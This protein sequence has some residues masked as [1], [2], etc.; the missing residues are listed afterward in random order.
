MPRKG[1]FR[2]RPDSRE[3][4]FQIA[5][6]PHWGPDVDRVL[7]GYRT[8]APRTRRLAVDGEDWFVFGFADEA[9]ARLLM[10]RGGGRWV[11]PARPRTSLG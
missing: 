5:V 4:P 1:E 9:E 11:A 3:H 8:V 6:P 2:L 10:L 7:K